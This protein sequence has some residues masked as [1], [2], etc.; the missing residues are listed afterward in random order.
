M[1]IRPPREPSLRIGA[2]FILSA[3]FVVSALFRA[4]DVVAQL[5]MGGDDGFGNP[6]VVQRGANVEHAEPAGRQPDDTA[7]APA[8]LMAELRHQREVLAESQRKLTEREQTLAVLQKHLE[9]RLADL[10]AARE[11]LADTAALVED[12]AGKDVRRLAEMYQ[13]MKPKQAGQ[14]FNEMA[15][16]FAAG[17]IAE[18]RA[19]AAALVLANMDAE[20]AYAVSLLLAGRNVDRSRTSAPGNR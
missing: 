5:P 10:A 14:I 4:G 3:G 8:S 6:V 13:Q 11:R 2:L 9:K 16:T 15:P 1:S 18:M 17:F 12:A 7:D 20:K 19:D